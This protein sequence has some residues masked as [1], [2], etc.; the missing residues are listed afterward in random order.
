MELGRR[1]FIKAGGAMALLSMLPNERVM[2]L[3][4]AAPLAGQAGHY[5]NAHQLD[6]LRALTGRFIPGPNDGPGVLNPP[7]GSPDP[8]AIEAKSPRPSTSSSAPSASNHR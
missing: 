1:T 2:S 8:G 7:P 4:A 6:T 5:L 3:L